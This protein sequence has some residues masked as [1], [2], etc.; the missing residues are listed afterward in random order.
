MCRSAYCTT[1]YIGKNVLVPKWRPSLLA[2][3]SKEV[4]SKKP[5]TFVIMQEPLLFC[6]LRYNDED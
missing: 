2:S 3:K 6:M 1:V 4:V 5:G